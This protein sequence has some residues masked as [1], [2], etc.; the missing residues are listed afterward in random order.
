LNKFV[1]EINH[2]A[3]IAIP[4]TKP[5]NKHKKPLPYWNKKVQEAVY[6]RNKARNKYT[7]SNI[8]EDAIEY[9]KLKSL[10][11]HTIKE[12]AQQCW[13][14]YCTTLTS[15]TKLG[16]IWQMAKRMNGVQDRPSARTIKVN[17]QEIVSNL[18]KANHFAQYFTNI[19]SNENH[20]PEFLEHKK[21]IEKNHPHLYSIDTSINEKTSILNDNFTIYELEQAIRLLKNNSAPGED[22]VIY[23]MI[24]HLPSSCQRV[25]LRIY[26]EIWCGGALPREWK[27]ALVLPFLKPGKDP[28][29]LDSYRPVSLTSAVCKLMERL[30]TNRLEWFVESNYLLS[31]VQSGFRKSR[32]T[33]DHIAR[34][35]DQINKALRNKSHTMGLF[36]D[37]NKAFD[38]V[39]TNGLL[40]KLKKIGVGGHM[41][42][43]IRDF[44]SDRTFQ[45]RIGNKLSSTYKLENGTP[46]GSVISPLLFLIMIDDLPQ[47]LQD[48]DVSLFADDTAIFK[49]SKNINHLNKVMQKNMDAIQQWADMWGFKIST[50]KTVI[51][52]FTNSS[53]K[54]KVNISLKGIPLKVKGSVKF[55]G[56]IFDQRLTWCEHIKYIKAKTQ[57]R[58]NLLRAVAGSNWGASS[59]TLLILYKLLIRSLLD[60]GDIAIDSASKSQK[61]ILSV[62]QSTALRICTG[63]MKTTEIEAMQVELNEMPLNLR[64]L[65]HQIEYTLKIKATH[66]H[67]NEN[68]IQDHWMNHYG[69][70]NEN[71]QTI[72]QKT[73]QFYDENKDVEID[74]VKIYTRPPWK[75]AKI[76]FDTDL[77]CEISKKESPQILLQ[78]T[79]NKVSEYNDSIHIFT[80]ASKHDELVGIGILIQDTDQ[81]INQ[82]YSL[83]LT[84]N[85]SIFT[86]ELTAIKIALVKLLRIKNTKDITIFS[87]SLS[88]LQA[89][90]GSQPTSAVNTINEIKQLINYLKHQVT[91]VWVP[92]HIGLKGNEQA[93]SLANE[94]TA[95][96]TTD[97]KILP[98]LG[99]VKK[100][101][102][103]Y[104]A[105]KW[106]NQWSN[107]KSAFKS[108]KPNIGP[109]VLKFKD[110]KSETTGFRLR[111]GQCRLNHYLHEIGCHPTGLCD[112]CNVSENIEH[113]LMKCDSDLVQG[114]KELCQRKNIPHTLTEILSTI[115]TLEYIADH[116]NRKI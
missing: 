116:C 112:T 107:S 55:L 3:S 93:D 61:K 79:R 12:E 42:R 90:M 18:D 37:F 88:S 20:S 89:I 108:L 115:V 80:D 109:N 103:K 16:P 24:K 43:W 105:N 27:H 95:K 2:A 28:G 29:L 15:H 41:F 78:L 7:R 101:A 14:D 51:V 87:D 75:L 97:I 62:I 46:Q 63:A 85:T 54:S 92:S 65:Q 84:D 49:T 52:L 36:L 74:K 102:R 114:L 11:Q 8:L 5:I 77:T 72:Y 67:T 50:E 26:N 56:M 64:R 91:I 35:Q 68:L 45:V 19:S 76:L 73:K 38:L 53:G 44:L 25:L 1:T 23:E 39:W 30:V 100:L 66:K 82:K 111:L 94:A 106:Q 99:E 48:V 34:L 83:R 33:M 104:I 4:Q 60:Y 59:Q 86:A 6:N 98:D 40:I 31:N 47:K 81:N 71:N 22:K 58:I 70:Y 96:H 10:A 21:D 32:S 113:F 57:R 9:K 69:K 110:R 17:N 13:H